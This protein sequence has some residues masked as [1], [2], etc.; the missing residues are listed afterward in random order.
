MTYTLWIYLHPRFAGADGLGDPKVSRAPLRSPHD[1]PRHHGAHG[2]RSPG[3]ERRH[4]WRR[5]CRRGQCITYQ[6]TVGRRS[7]PHKPVNT[8]D[9]AVDTQHQDVRKQGPHWYPGIAGLYYD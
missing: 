8:T 9:N 6:P 2:R 7:A 1:P 3:G 4:R 5:R